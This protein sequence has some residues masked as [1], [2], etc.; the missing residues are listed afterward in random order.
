MEFRN[1][2]SVRITATLKLLDMACNMCNTMTC[3]ASLTEQVGTTNLC[4]VD[5]TLGVTIK[6]KDKDFG[7]VLKYYANNN[8]ML[9][10]KSI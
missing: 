4:V 8:V 5:V 10:Q 9:F 6:L 2:S 3:I 7:G 1:T